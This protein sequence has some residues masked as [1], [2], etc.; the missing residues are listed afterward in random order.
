MA[1]KKYFFRQR[2]RYVVALTH[3]RAKADHLLGCDVEGKDVTPLVHQTVEA[4]IR[5][6]AR[7]IKL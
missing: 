3:Q 5:R 6:I 1:G 2:C 4:I 7:R